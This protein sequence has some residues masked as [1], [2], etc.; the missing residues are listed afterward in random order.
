MVPL[1]RSVPELQAAG[2]DDGW[3]AV[4]VAAVQDGLGASSHPSSEGDGEP[5]PGRVVR[6]DRGGALVLLAPAVGEEASAGVGR[7]VTVQAPWGPALA[8]AV[9]HDPTRIPAAGDWVVLGASP[10]VGGRR[11]IMQVLPRRTA[12]V[13]LQASQGSS[14]GQ[15]LAAN[16]DVVVV[17]EAMTPDLEP[18]RLER[19]LALA[20]SSGARPVVVL[21]KADLVAS[22]QDLVD[23]VTDLAPGVEVLAV[24]ALAGQGLEPLRAA[25]ADGSSIALLGASGAGKST[26][27]N[28]L[29]GSGG[30]P[31]E[32]MRTRPPR[33]DGKGRHTT[34]TRELH[35]APD[36]GAVLDTPGLRSVGL[37]GHQSLDEVFAEVDELAGD[38]RFDDCTHGCEPGCA[39]LTVVEEGRLPERRLASYRKLLREAEYQASRVDAR[40]RAERAG[41]WRRIHREQRRQGN[42]P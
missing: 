36:G 28:A 42:R 3:T 2:W 11:T 5:V 18:A 26:L 17:V 35:L 4:F 34:V 40:L 13:R 16:V 20:W 23:D 38:C 22:P 10:G 33:T 21:T 37:L 14:R 39:V 27:L 15:V 1:S 24:A 29:V 9:A 31:G 8:A 12:V 25:L 7:L 41:R 19:L 6:A 32:V 30:E